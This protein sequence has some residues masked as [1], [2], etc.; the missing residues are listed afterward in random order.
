MT[1]FGKELRKLRIDRSEIMRTMAGKLGITSAYLSAIEC[2]KRNIPD[3]FID[4]ITTI[5]ELNNEEKAKLEDNA[6]I[7]NHKVLIDFNYVSDSKRKLVLKFARS[8][9]DIDDRTAKKI[10]ALLNN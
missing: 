1:E 9:D 7:A 3:D 2:G 10:T 6:A 8:F 4:K 5:Y